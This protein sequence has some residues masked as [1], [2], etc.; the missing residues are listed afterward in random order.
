MIHFILLPGPV[1]DDVQQN[2]DRRL[3]VLGGWAIPVP[4]ERP[5]W[6]RENGK[7]EMMKES[8]VIMKWEGVKRGT[9]GYGMCQ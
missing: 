3:A 2:I 8:E 6:G 1:L 5:R 7:G 4:R 9:S